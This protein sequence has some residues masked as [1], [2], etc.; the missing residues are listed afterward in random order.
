[1]RFRFFLPPSYDGLLSALGAPDHLRRRSRRLGAFRSWAARRSKE[2]DIAG[3]IQL[4]ALIRSVWGSRGAIPIP[5]LHIRHTKT[6]P[7]FAP[8]VLS[9]SSFSCTANRP[10]PIARVHRLLKRHPLEIHMIP[11]VSSFRIFTSD[12][13]PS[14]HPLLSLQRFYKHNICGHRHLDSW[15]ENLI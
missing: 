15:L 10:L 3:N 1:M 7:A 11:Y 4:F 12:L 14:I 5:E 8:I 9:P 13:F 2:T 6:H